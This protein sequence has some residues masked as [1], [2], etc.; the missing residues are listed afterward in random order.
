LFEIGIMARRRPKNQPTE[1][2]S[3]EATAERI[4]PFDLAA[5]AR[6]LVG[7]LPD[8]TLAEEL[9]LL[10]SQVDAL[11]AQAPAAV[12]LPPDPT[13]PQVVRDRTALKQVAR[14]IGDADAVVI[15][16]ETSDL[17]PRSGEIVGLGLA[18]SEGCHYVPVAHRVE[19]TGRLRPDQL[20]LVAVVRDLRLHQLPLV[21]H[22]AKFEFRWLRRHAG[23]ACNFV[24]DVM[25]A[26]RL[27][28]SHLSAELKDVAARELD[29]PDWGMSKADIERIQF[30]PIERVARYCAKD[31]Y[32]TLQLYRR[33]QSCL[34]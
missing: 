32:Y 20:P 4:E 18:T 10:H 7:E 17:N 23:V 16:L 24:W 19:E 21:G 28:E 5:W 13:A 34:A 12:A 25:L 14:Q 1:R 29:V 3:G 15:D 31:C 33:Q 30:L 11:A 9:A 8:D 2:S 22:N 26:T 27:L 6:R